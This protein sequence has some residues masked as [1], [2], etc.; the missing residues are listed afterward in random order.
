F[1]PYEIGTYEAGFITFKIPLSE[2]SGMINKN[3]AFYLSF[4]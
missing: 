3:G 1:P 2:I 4:N